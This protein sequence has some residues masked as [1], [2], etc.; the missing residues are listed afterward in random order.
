M[1]EL[2][3]KPGSRTPSMTELY[4][5]PGSRGPPKQITDSEFKRPTIK[6]YNP[7]NIKKPK[8]DGGVVD[9]NRDRL[10]RERFAK[11]N[12]NGLRVSRK[13]LDKVIDT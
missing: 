7:D 1:T 9:F 5:R 4:N 13:S 8:P 12:K 2:Y 11:R 10:M 6:L 3:E